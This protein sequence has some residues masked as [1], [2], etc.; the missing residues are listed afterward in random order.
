MDL[1]TGFN[2][3]VSDAGFKCFE[4]RSVVETGRSGMEFGRRIGTVDL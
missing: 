2:S 4:G 1:P 3:S